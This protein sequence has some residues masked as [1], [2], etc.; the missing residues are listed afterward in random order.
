MK[1]LSKVRTTEAM[2]VDVLAKS[3]PGKVYN[4]AAGD[5]N[6]P[7]CAALRRAYGEAAADDTHNYASSAGL[8]ELRK[9]LW[10]AA[11]EV[12]IANGA[13]Q[14][15][16]MSLAA[17]SVPGDKV[18][19][20]GPCWASYMRICD[21]LGLKY[22]LLT[23]SA[24]NRYV[25]DLSDVVS[26]ITPDTA[27]V[28]MNS[29]N[30]PTGVIYGREY[31]SEV[32]EVVRRCDSRLI[33]DEIYRCIVDAPFMSLRG[34]KD[35]IVIDGFSKSLN[36][37]GWRLGYAIAEG[38]VISSM[39]AIQSQ[40]SGPPSTLIQKIAAAAYDDLE[41]STFE[42]YRERIDIL[43]EIP[44]FAAARPAGGFYFY[45]PIDEHWES[46]KALCEF[47][48]REY[49]VAV[50]PGDDYGVGRTVR[51][52]VASEPACSLRETL[53]ALRLI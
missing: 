46:S 16:Y 6:L 34:E 18:V 22:T 13:K 43:C 52:S 9:K 51:I 20:I 19:I 37:T 29:P 21:I 12:I 45:V 40:M 25:P 2:L 24:E 33:M 11:D 41:F 4:L 5:P 14:L 3:M 28:L 27:A 15:I 35:V 38:D 31:V 36:I 26:A 49:S 48:L 42:D 32:L 39:T 7:V 44:K 50:T 1:R 10:P 53:D 23:G 47:L 8:P 17:V 30:N